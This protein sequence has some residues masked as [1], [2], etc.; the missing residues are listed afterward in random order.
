MPQS[1]THVFL[2]LSS[3]LVR[4]RMRHALAN[5]F[6]IHVIDEVS[7][8]VRAAEGIRACEPQVIVCDE[9]M[10]TDPMLLGVLRGRRGQFAY[11]V[12]LI[13]GNARVGE[14]LGGIQIVDQLPID[15]PADELAQRLHEAA[16]SEMRP[17]KSAADQRSQSQRLRVTQ[18]QGR[19]VIAEQPARTPS[20]TA[21]IVPP[22]VLF[23][24]GLPDPGM[25]RATSNQAYLAPRGITSGL[26]ARTEPPAAAPPA[27]SRVEAALS[28]RLNGKYT[29]ST[30]RRSRRATYER[31]A[32]VFR[33]MQA[34]RTHL[35]RDD[36]TGLAN[37]RGL[38][39]A[40]RA[41]PNVNQPAGVLVLDLWYGSDSHVPADPA[42]QQIFLS[43]LGS[44]IGGTVRQD[45]LLCR[46]EGMTFAIVL[47]GLD[48]ETAPIPM[49]RLRRA[50]ANVRYPV[51]GGT[52]ELT[53]AMGSGFWQPGVPSAEPLD[54][55]WQAM[56][57]E[58][59]QPR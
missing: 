23:P 17:E 22:T 48:A 46:I 58:R 47:P 33:A 12:V 25:P 43:S 49:Q 53:V 35:Q 50:L 4:I 39:M 42:R 11:R 27:M 18:A 26:G 10:M 20:K 13:T 59:A 44:V 3:P 9:R 30:C 41:L 14:Q 56:K 19:F 51:G 21:P 52:G 55:A 8:P 37:T 40:L 38:G 31:L 5:T 54:R 28:G 1:V 45:D 32:K 24:N 2:A 6:G 29:G 15:L 34:E 36:L 16:I 57:A 7:D